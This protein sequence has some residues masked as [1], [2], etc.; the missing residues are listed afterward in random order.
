MVRNFNKWGPSALLALVL[1]MG[2]PMVFED[3]FRAVLE[4]P[5]RVLDYNEGSVGVA[6]VLVGLWIWSCCRLG[7]VVRESWAWAVIIAVLKFLGRLVGMLA[8]LARLAPAS[9]RD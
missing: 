9:W 8:L 6:A 7:L 3:E 1:S 2:V 5:S 4:H